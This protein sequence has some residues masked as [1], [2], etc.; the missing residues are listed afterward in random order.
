MFKVLEVDSLVNYSKKFHQNVKECRDLIVKKVSE[1]GRDARGIQHTPFEPHS[2]LT[3][4]M[5]LWVQSVC[6]V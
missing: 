3:S 4:R 1:Q 6:D 5:V 2:A